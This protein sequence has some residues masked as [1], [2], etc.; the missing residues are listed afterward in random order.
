MATVREITETLNISKQ[1]YKRVKKANTN[2]WKLEKCERIIRRLENKE[3]LD[4]DLIPSENLKMRKT[5]GYGYV[6][7]Y[8][9]EGIEEA[10]DKK[11]NRFY[12]V[13]TKRD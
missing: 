8:S 5:N 10:V 1:K 12:T 2:K 11:I 7:Y 13:K 4:R 3:R 9:R 6:L